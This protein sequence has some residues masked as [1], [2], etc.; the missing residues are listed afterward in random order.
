MTHD[1]VVQSFN[2]LL[3]LDSGGELKQFRPIN[4]S[5][6]YCG[7]D[8]KP[9][10][11]VRSM[12]HIEQSALRWLP[13]MYGVCPASSTIKGRHAATEKVGLAFV[14]PHREACHG[15]HGSILRYRHIMGKPQSTF[16]TLLNVGNDVS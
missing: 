8:W 11:A 5:I 10:P 6:I 13:T 9:V 14:Q 2:E 15:P 4:Q 1:E 12:L 7:A 3:A 16:V